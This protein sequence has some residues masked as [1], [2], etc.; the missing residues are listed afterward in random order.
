MF[1]GLDVHKKY[2]EAAIVDDEGVIAGQERLENKPE[3]IE[4]FSEK[5]SNATIVMESSSTWYWLYEILSKR[6][7]VVLSNPVK[8]KAIASAKL[9]TD[10]VD[11]LML[12][13]LLR[14]GYIAEC[15][16]PSRHLMGLRELVRY[17][18]NLIRIR[19]TVKNRIHSYLLMNN[20][21]IEYAP[22][23]KGFLKELGKVEDARVQG[24][25]RIIERLN[26]EIREASKIVCREA[27]NDEGARL[28]MTIP[29][30]S[31]Y[32][33]LLVVSEIGDIGRF[34]DSSHLVSYAGLTPS[35][36]SSGGVT[37]HG[38]ITKTGSPYLRWVLNQCTWAHMRAAPDGCVAEF[39]RRLSRKKGPA[40]AVVASS[41]KLLKIVYWVLREGRPYYS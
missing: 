29:G 36:R 40:K 38:R 22:F 5:L 33:A 24:Y 13:N 18:A 2:T 14:G 28:L 21:R 12:A 4:A 1:V 35:T 8:T 37:Y 25:L 3:L 7:K 39:Y 41:A 11:A 9:K 31:F 27:M 10:K 34:P 19:G 15:Y 26:L 6:H 30:F 32:S 16:V 23:T 20:V 17:R